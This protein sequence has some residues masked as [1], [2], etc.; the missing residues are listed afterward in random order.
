MITYIQDSR[1]ILWFH[2]H[3]PV[4]ADA[5]LFVIIQ[6]KFLFE[7][8]KEVIL[9]HWRWFILLN[10][11][12]AKHIKTIIHT[13]PLKERD[14]KKKYFVFWIRY[15]HKIRWNVHIKIFNGRFELITTMINLIEIF[16]AV[17]FCHRY[18]F[19]TGL[20]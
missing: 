12:A 19:L 17:F 4:S 15:L 7:R 8:P 11:T 20:I 3:M 10:G 13:Q 16:F 6:N 14:K 5:K 2:I 9:L 1:D 18:V